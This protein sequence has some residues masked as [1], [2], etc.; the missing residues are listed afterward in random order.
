MNNNLSTAVILTTILFMVVQA[1][2]E[3]SYQ[4]SFELRELTTPKH[5]IGNQEVDQTNIHDET[6]QPCSMDP[7]TG[8]MRNGY[9]QTNEQ[10]RGA[11]VVCAY[12]TDEFLTYTKGM[13]ND[14]S[15]PAPQYSFPGLK[16]GDKWCLCAIRWKQAYDA[17]KAPLVVLQSTNAVALQYVEKS[18]LEAN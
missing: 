12:M 4:T 2:S 11:H 3:T 15:T 14:L 13:G 8:W 5:F 10:D 9:C 18:V 7:L 16:A 6:L 17:G 1:K